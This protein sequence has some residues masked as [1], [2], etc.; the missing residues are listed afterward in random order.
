[1]LPGP[2]GLSSWMLRYAASTSCTALTN[3][4]NLSLSSGVFHQSGNFPMLPPFIRGVK[5]VPTITITDQ[6]L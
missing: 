6:F 3:L 4:F 1:M 5:E 2:D